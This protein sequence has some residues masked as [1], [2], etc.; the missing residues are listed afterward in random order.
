MNTLRCHVDLRYLI[1]EVNRMSLSN[2]PNGS[3]AY[4]GGDGYNEGWIHG[5]ANA[6]P[7]LLDYPHIRAAI[8]SLQRRT[9]STL[10]QVM[11]NKLEP[12]GMLQPHR[13]APPEFD[14]YHLPIVTNSDA[15]WWDE[16]TGKFHMREGFW[17]GP[18]PYC[19]VLHSV[20]NN[21]ETERVHVVVDLLRKG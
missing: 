5:F 7:R 10:H 3:G 21:G 20:E 11:V 19:G 15:W 6:R 18:V 9:G 13:D 1:G 2:I 14:R 12:G 17:Y 4:H 8:F 16:Y